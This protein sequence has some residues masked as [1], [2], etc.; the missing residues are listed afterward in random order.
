MKFKKVLIIITAILILI[1][2]G[3]T[4]YYI[5]AWA[6]AKKI[7]PI[8]ITT[9][10]TTTQ[11]EEN[12]E[13]RS[14]DYRSDLMTRNPG[15]TITDYTVKEVVAVALD[16]LNKCKQFSSDTQGEA[17]SFGITQKIVGKRVVK[18]DLSYTTSLSSGLLKTCYDAFFDETDVKYR[19]TNTVNDLVPVYD[20]SKTETITYE[21][22]I[23]RYGSLPTDAI[24]YVIN[25]KTYLAD[26]TMEKL[27]DGN[28]K[29]KMDLNPAGDMA[30]FWFKR[31]VATNG[32]SDYEP[33]FSRIHIEITINSDFRILSYYTEETYKVYSII[34]ATADT[35]YTEVFTYDN[36]D[37]PEEIKQKYLK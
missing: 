30:P 1:G 23:S 17:K 5:V 32:S 18:D 15:K 20:D 21:E 16:T 27:T 34:A 37:F 36:V 26:P 12:Y 8:V 10:Q 25:S 24:T 4:I 19:K 33:E 28:Y 9:T 29:I 11:K 22:F 35:K 14:E 31:S 3:I 2:I 7:D 6:G 13:M